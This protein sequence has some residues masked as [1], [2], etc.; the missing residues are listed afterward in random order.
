M[1]DYRLAMGSSYELKVQLVATKD[2]K[3]INS[4]KFDRVNEDIPT[5]QKRLNVLISFVKPRLK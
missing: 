1:L 2:L 3:L 4:E 5:F